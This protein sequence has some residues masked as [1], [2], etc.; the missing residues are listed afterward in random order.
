MAI[1]PSELTS[2]TLL[3]IDDTCASTS[4]AVPKIRIC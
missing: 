3:T 2:R 4:S 1:D